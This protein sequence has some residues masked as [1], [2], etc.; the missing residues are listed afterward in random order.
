M[1]E[2]GIWNYVHGTSAGFMPIVTWEAAHSMW[3]TPI[4]LGVC[5]LTSGVL[6]HIVH[7]HRKHLRSV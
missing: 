2:L 4:A 7:R 6:L 5:M 3:S 1:E